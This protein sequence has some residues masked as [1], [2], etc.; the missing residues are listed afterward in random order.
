MTMAWR[1]RAALLLALVVLVLTA[2]LAVVI[3]LMG[4]R[5]PQDSFWTRCV[6]R[7]LLCGTML[8]LLYSAVLKKTKH[9]LFKAIYFI[10]KCWQTVLNDIPNDFI[11]HINVSMRYM[12]SNIYDAS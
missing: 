9:R 6:L 11:I 7:I 12:V 4:V 8:F 10:D 1:H 3:A 5:I 2:A